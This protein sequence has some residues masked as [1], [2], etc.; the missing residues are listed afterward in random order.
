[1]TRTPFNKLIRDRIP[2]IIAQNGGRAKIST[3]SPPQF[4]ASL[5]EKLLEEA[6]ELGQAKTRKEILNELA[7][8]AELLLALTTEFKI[9]KKELEA[10]RQ[11]KK[12]ER[13]GFEK[14]LYL[15]YVEQ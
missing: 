11:K 6:I 14:K 1:M 9:P 2:Q 4:R 3:L 8:I 13:G 15:H 7:D 10:T 12:K 5:K